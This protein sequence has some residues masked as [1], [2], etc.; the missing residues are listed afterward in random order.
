VGGGEEEKA[1]CVFFSLVSPWKHWL[2]GGQD[3]TAREEPP[4]PQ[5]ID[6][7]NFS[8]LAGSQRCGAGGQCQAPGCTA[9]TERC[10]SWSTLPGN[11]AA[12]VIMAFDRSSLPWRDSWPP[13]LGVGMAGD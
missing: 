13:V 12:V 10:S 2:E 5:R 4:W 6:W 11:S 1:V 8:Y 7:G 3:E 9:G